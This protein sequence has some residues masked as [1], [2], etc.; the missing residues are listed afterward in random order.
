L[1]GLFAAGGAVLLGWVLARFVLEIPAN[2][3]TLI[4]LVGV[5]GGIVIVMLSGWLATRKLIQ[6]PPLRI[7]AAD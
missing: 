4:W 6:R 3:D 1:S 7:L 2:F 5:S